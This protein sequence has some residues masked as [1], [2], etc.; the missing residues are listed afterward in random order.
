VSANPIG[1]TLEGMRDSLLGGARISDVWEDAAI[2]LPI[3]AASLALGAVAFKFALKRE[4]RSGT[5]GLY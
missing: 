4:R 2:L 1:I 3:A 5:L